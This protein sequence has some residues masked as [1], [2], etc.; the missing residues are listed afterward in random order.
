MFFFEYLNPDEY[1]QVQEL[2]FEEARLA[3]SYLAN[4]HAYYWRLCDDEPGM[5][6]FIGNRTNLQ[7]VM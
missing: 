4:F 2:N 1:E 7:L 3:L 6:G 5:N